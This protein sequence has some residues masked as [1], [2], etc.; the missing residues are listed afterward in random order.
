MKPTP[1][2]KNGLHLEGARKWGLCHK[3]QAKRSHN[4]IEDVVYLL[5]NLWTQFKAPDCVAS[6]WRSDEY[7]ATEPFTI[8]FGK[9]GNSRVSQVAD[10][11]PFKQ[12]LGVLNKILTRSIAPSSPP[13]QFL[14]TQP[15]PFFYCVATQWVQMWCERPNAL[16]KVYNGAKGYTLEFQVCWRTS[17]T[18]W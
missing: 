12:K 10:V 13:L 5:M 16:Y 6:S 15:K 7:E 4:K 17:W 1:S 8:L 18:I 14:V 3:L 2:H 9:P 11:W